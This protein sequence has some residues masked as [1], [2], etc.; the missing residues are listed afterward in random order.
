MA[1][2]RARNRAPLQPRRARTGST[3]SPASVRGTWRAD[4]KE[5]QW[6]GGRH[7]D[8]SAARSSVD[9][10]TGTQVCAGDLPR[11]FRRTPAGAPQ[12]SS[13]AGCGAAKASTQAPPPP[14]PGAGR[15]A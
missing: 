8:R 13:R 1:C 4:R 11:L 7:R 3:G 12:A 5:R 6:P 9:A 10:P 15:R 14:R 2:E